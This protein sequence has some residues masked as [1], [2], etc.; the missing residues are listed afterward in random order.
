MKF[1]KPKGTKDI[2]PKEIGRWHHVE[3]VIREVT[4]N[5]NFSEIRTPTFENTELFTRGVGTETD[6]VGKE[7]YTF[8]DK[9]D[10]SLTLRPEMTAPVARA[11]LENGLANE[12]P[13]QKLYYVSN[14]FRYEKPQEARYREHTQFGAE[15]LGTD[16]ISS[17]VEIILLAKEVFNRCGINDFILK[18]NSIGKADERKKYVLKLKEYLGKRFEELSDDSKRRYNNNP[19]RI[20]DS[21]DEKDIQIINSAPKIMDHLTTDSRQR[22]DKLLNELSLLGVDYE[23]DFRL[24]RGLDY[25]TDTTYEFISKILGAQDAIGGGGR[26]DGLVET[27]GGKPTYGIGFASGLERLLLVSERNNFSFPDNDKLKV[28]II[29]LND[30]AKHLSL[31]ICS[32]LRKANLSCD[33]DMLNRSLKSQMREANKLNAEYVYIIGD[34]EIKKQKGILKKMSGGTQIEISHDQVLE[35]IK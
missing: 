25:Y 28:Y 7:M 16:D 8:K 4:K 17:D 20:L 1:Q 3:R 31:K 13:I 27:I 19:L 23:I 10:N 2:L 21:K 33:A 5:F 24:V 14:I 34:E 35:Y 26:Y 6:I 18:I 12:S 32:D 29:A 22:F 30:E 9:G 15:I 11:F